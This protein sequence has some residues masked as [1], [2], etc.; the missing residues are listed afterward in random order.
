MTVIKKV[1]QYPRLTVNQNK[2]NMFL[3]QQFKCVEC[4][5]GANNSGDVNQHFSVSVYPSNGAAWSV[6]IGMTLIKSG[7]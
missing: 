1:L 2:K 3:K 7:Q 6:T 4:G 5:Q